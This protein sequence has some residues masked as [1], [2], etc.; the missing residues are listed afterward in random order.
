M[1]TG[2]FLKLAE[3]KG[4][5]FTVKAGKFYAHAESPGAKEWV[6]KAAEEIE[7]RKDAI[8]LYLY[9]LTEDEDAAIR[10]WLSRIEE[11]DPV[12]IDEVLDKC[13]TEPDAKDYFLGQASEASAA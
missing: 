10:V 8:I 12:V 2:R 11:S 13:R 6:R 1:D 4:V 5:T 7:K 3:S 9:A